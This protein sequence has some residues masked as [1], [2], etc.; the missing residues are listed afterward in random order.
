MSLRILTIGRRRILC[1][2]LQ[3]QLT[4]VLSL[5]GMANP[6][7]MLKAAFKGVQILLSLQRKARTKRRLPM[8]WCAAAVPVFQT[9]GHLLQAV[10]AIFVIRQSPRA[11]RNSHS[12]PCHCSCPTSLMTDGSMPQQV[13]HVLLTFPQAGAGTD[14]PTCTTMSI[15]TNTEANRQQ[16]GYSSCAMPLL[17]CS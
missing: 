13:V 17:V 11:P 10:A 12:C 7:G 6:R 5:F 14:H 3:F 15:M 4:N 16:Q 2:S 9:E 1:L 8:R